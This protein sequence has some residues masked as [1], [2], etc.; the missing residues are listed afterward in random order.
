MLACEESVIAKDK[1]DRSLY[2]FGAGAFVGAWRSIIFATTILGR[3]C[4]SRSARWTCLERRLKS[5][6]PLYTS[7]CIAFA[8]GWSL[9]FLAGS[10]QN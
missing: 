9:I 1:I 6:D 3:L 7:G 4:Y 5:L 10:E 8:S 2:D